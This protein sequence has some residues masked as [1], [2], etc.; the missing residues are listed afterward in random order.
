VDHV[1]A[2][3]CYVART[4]LVWFELHCVYRTSKDLVTWSEPAMALVQGPSHVERARHGAS[5]AA[6]DITADIQQVSA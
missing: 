2:Q 4:R 5:A 3:A 6:V 1:G